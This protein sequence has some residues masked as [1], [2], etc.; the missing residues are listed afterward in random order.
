MNNVIP[1]D[2]HIG[3]KER[4]SLKGHKPLVIW[5]TG[6]S[7]SGKSTLANIVEQALSKANVHTY[8]LDGDNIRRGINRDLGFSSEERT[9]NLRRI[10]EIAKLFADSGLVVL[11]AFI[12]PMQKERDFIKATVGAD[13]FMEVF[14][15]TSVE[16][17]ER[18]DVKGLYK[19]ARQGEIKNFTGI[20]APFEPPLNPDLIIKTETINIEEAAKGIINSINMKIQPT[21]EL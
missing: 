6:L 14:V 8:T 15:D 1:Q 3:L 10:A 7:G 20:N 11:A 12:T 17:C 2:Y 18:R 16:E 9:E 4:S 19:K 21:N 13:Q 5:F